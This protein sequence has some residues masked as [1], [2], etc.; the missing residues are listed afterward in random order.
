MPAADARL[1]SHA[2]VVLCRD[3]RLWASQLGIPFHNM[4]QVPSSCSQALDML[5]HGFMLCLGVIFLLKAELVIEAV[6]DSP[7]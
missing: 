2:A 7:P 1:R 4:K 3:D 6:S 5:A